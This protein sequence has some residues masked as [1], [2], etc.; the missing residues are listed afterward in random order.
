MKITL[1]LFAALREHM[2]THHNGAC[3]VSLGEIATVQDVLE[4][5]RIPDDIPKIILINGA[6]KSSCD[7]LH[8]GDTLSVFPPIAGG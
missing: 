5:F 3:E 7:V 2:I 4:K 8:N 6:Q 1:K